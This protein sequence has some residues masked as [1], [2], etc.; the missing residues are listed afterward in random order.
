MNA[1]S[2]ALVDGNEVVLFFAHGRSGLNGQEGK[3]HIQKD[4]LIV[5]IGVT[6]KA[7]TKPSQIVLSWIRR[8]NEK[9]VDVH[10]IANAC[11]SYGHCPIW[12]WL[13]VQ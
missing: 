2:K 3:I 1:Q 13:P 7:L 8:Y 4:A 6:Q 11:L 9:S 10:L 5:A 12:K